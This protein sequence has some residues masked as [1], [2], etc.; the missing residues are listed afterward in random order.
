LDDSV[1]GPEIVCYGTEGWQTF[2]SVVDSME[3]SSCSLASSRGLWWTMQRL[4]SD[5][6][7]FKREIYISDTVVTQVLNPVIF[8]L[9]NHLGFYPFYR[10]WADILAVCTLYDCIFFQGPKITYNYNLPRWFWILLR[11]FTQRFVHF[12]LNN[13]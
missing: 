2:Q 10:I 12:Q 8:S 13:M 11:C 4:T 5:N 7:R 6:F 1:L 3:S 9:G